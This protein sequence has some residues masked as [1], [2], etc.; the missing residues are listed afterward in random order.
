M[1]NGR[2]G[3]GREGGRKK[4]GKEREGGKEGGRDGGREGWKGGKEND[5]IVIRCLYEHHH[6]LQL[7][8]SLILK[9]REL[10]HTPLLPQGDSSDVGT[11]D[12]S[13]HQQNDQD[14]NYHHNRDDNVDQIHL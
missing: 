12:H 1:N 14:D 8:I 2:E 5:D 9:L 7:Y 13:H 4:G 11:E 6:L 10:V 3:E